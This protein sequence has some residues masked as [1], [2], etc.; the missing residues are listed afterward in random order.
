MAMSASERAG[1]AYLPTP[2]TLF[3]RFAA[4]AVVVLLF[5]FIL[6]VYLTFWL[7]WPGASAA[8]GP[9][10]PALSWLQVLLYALA[11]GGPAAYVL[12]ARSRS[13]RRFPGSMPRC[14][15]TYR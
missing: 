9:D 12:G 10:G 6:N 8:F 7:D 5:G 11:I 13:L 2:L 14:V 15:E 3:F 4:W 1:E